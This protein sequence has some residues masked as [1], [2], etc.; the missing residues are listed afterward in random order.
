[1]HA[2]PYLVIA[3]LSL[4]PSLSDA[5][6]QPVNANAQTIS[7]FLKRVEEYVAFHKKLEST[8]PDLPK[9]T[10]PAEVD[11]HQ[12]AL[13]KLM[14]ENRTDA[15]RG[16]IFGDAMEHHI[17]VLLRPVFQGRGGKQIR[18][19]I[20]DNEYKGDV[21]LRVNARY[22]D[23]VPLSTVP[24]QVLLSLPKLPEELEYR[25]IG[26]SLILL[27]VHAHTIADFMERAYH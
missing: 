15:K 24:P 22:P 14:Q 1:M 4:A 26:T 13:G 2:F 3:L 8:L 10:D 21:P 7:D 11:K 17:R 16:D 27:D 23:E 19:E 25:F 6:K 12:R 20:H 9:Q 18:N 5:Q